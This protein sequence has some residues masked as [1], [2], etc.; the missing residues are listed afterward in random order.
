MPAHNEDI[1]A[2]FEEMADLLEIENANPFRVRAYRNAARTVRGMGRELAEMVADGEDLT[3]LPGIGKDLSAKI[4]EIVSTGHA[5]ALDRLHRE[6][7]AG[8]EDMLRLPGLGPRRVR[9]LYDRLHI[10]S[11]K[12]LA[13]AARR[14]RLREL[15][16]FGEKTEQNIL[17]AIAAQRS[18]EK[19]FMHRVAQ[20][21]AGPL[22]D[23]L[24]AV[25]GVDEVVVA[26]SYRRGRETVGD[27][28]ILATADAGGRVTRRFTEYEDVVDVV[29][30]G[31][32]RSTVY[33]RNG[34]QVDLR[35][36][37]SRC[38]GAALQYFTGS[39]AHS[40]AIRRLGQKRGLKINEYGVFRGDRSIA[41]HTEASVYEAL[42]LPWI[43]PELRE[44]RGEIEAARR[45]RLPKL[46]E[47]S[48]L[49]GDLHVH[50]KATDGS[51]SVREMARAAKARGLKYI[52]ITDH[53]RHLTVAHG[54]DVRRLEQQ[55][56]EIDELNDS[57]RGITLLKGI[58]A[59]ILE[60]GH[61]DM[62]EQVLARLDMVIGAV[63]SRFRLSRRKQ[64]ERI[65]RAMD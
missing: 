20:R 65:L 54:L 63:H 60:D 59:D 7:P 25:E 15:P 44:N 24:R 58:E 4:V 14:G 17:E 42:D 33:L 3:Q 16:G 29:S 57:L 11:I 52:A 31:S 10:K 12:Q 37:D 39:K 61:L 21:Y 64:T 47:R 62:P 18:S 51:A 5:K 13:D 38:F 22:V 46:I 49:Q 41:G 53:S 27:L 28:D 43:P 8:L 55:I 40:I 6:V 45:H 48:D 19:R 2:I 56:D 9:T 30:R 26:G 1:A 32:T 34:L 50:S 36:V 23:Y 35:V